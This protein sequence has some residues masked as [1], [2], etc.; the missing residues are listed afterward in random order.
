M[1]LVTATV[2]DQANNIYAN[3]LVEAI[4]IPAPGITTLSL[5]SGSVFSTFT[6]GQTDSF[7]ALTM[8]LTGSDL[9]TPAGSVWRFNVLNNART[10]GFS[11][12]ISITGATQDITAALQAAAALINTPTGFGNITTQSI[13]NS[14]AF[15]SFDAT[16]GPGNLNLSGP[17][18]ATNIISTSSTINTGTGYLFSGDTNLSR[19]A[20]GVVDVGNGTAGNKSGRVNLTT[21]GVYKSDGTVPAT[22]TNDTSGGINLTNNAGNTWQLNSLGSWVSPP[23]KVIALSGSSSGSTVLQPAAV[24]SGTWTL[25]AATDTFVGKSTTD[26]LGNKDITGAGSNNKITLLNFQGPAAAKVG[27][28]TDQTLFTFTIPA[29]VVQTNKGLKLYTSFQQTT[30]AGAITYK[31]ILGG[32]TIFSIVDSGTSLITTTVYIWANGS[33]TVQTGSIFGADGSTIIINNLLTTGGENFANALALKWTFNVANT[34]SVTP[35]VWVLEL[36]Q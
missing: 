33:Q 9:I 32:T 31:L 6:A 26:V 11:T 15:S 10:V 28:S 19:D 29:N 21:L 5:A 16:I 30:G 23:G 8:T 7:G 1:T 25:P 22:I 2:K 24:A 36:V 3:A 20:A 35:D 34:S 18:L 13:I 17:F 12:Q 14:G 27:N 4:F